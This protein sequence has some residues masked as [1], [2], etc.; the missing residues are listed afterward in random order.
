MKK[1]SIIP[2]MMGLVIGGVAI[3]IGLDKL[4]EAQAS[5]RRDM[6]LTVVA[7]SEI[8]ATAPIQSAMVSLVETPKTPLVDGTCFADAKDVVGRVAAHS[9]PRG[10]VIREALLTPKGTPP[11]LA[12][13]IMPGFRAVSVKV[14]EV[15]GV[16]YQIQPGAFVD[17]IAVMTVNKGRHK[18]TIS[19]IILQNIEVA[20]VGQALNSAGG[21]GG[22]SK[23]AKSVTVLVRDSD[24]PMLHLAQTR[25]QLTLAL[26]SGDDGTLADNAGNASESDLL[27]EEPFAP[28]P[29]ERPSRS[30]PVHR[31]SV[32]VI[33]GGSVRE[34]SFGGG[35]GAETSGGSTAGTE[36]S[37]RTPRSNGSSTN[38][39]SGG[40]ADDDDDDDGFDDKRPPT[41]RPGV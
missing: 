22:S 40:N 10:V 2:L 20:A 29:R 1:V 24:A 19:R 31:G 39:G 27:G 32:T 21:E 12:V 37:H 33:N 9:I 34:H 5:G 41:Y 18:E 35:D 25:G 16:A 15:T 3:K 28:A 38:P 17:I 6:I 8:P 14:N 26:R 30:G 36:R 11:G 7:T 4:Q 23:V 13:R